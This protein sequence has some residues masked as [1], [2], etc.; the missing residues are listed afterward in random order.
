MA[1]S[2]FPPAGGVFPA[3]VTGLPGIATD[4]GFDVLDRS[5]SEVRADS[6]NGFMF[7]A[8]PSNRSVHM[9]TEPGMTGESALPG[10]VSGTLG[11]PFNVNLLAVWLANQYY[12]LRTGANELNDITMSRYE[13][14]SR[15][16]SADP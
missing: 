7:D 5:D 14:R 1:R 2:A 16:L 6:A 4:G 15:H 11:C 3:S 10:G 12:P 13:I 9:A 8:G